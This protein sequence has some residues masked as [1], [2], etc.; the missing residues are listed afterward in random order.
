MSKK[1][2]AAIFDMDGTLI[3]SMWVWEKIDVEFLKKRNLEIP[4]NL[5]SDIEHMNF[6]Q[7]A[8]YF[9]NRFHLPD[10]IDE[11]T[12]EWN[13]M[14]YSHYVNDVTLKNGVKE[15]LKHLKANGTK[16]GL[17]TSN[18]LMLIEAVLKKLEIYDFFDSITT[19]DEVNKGKDFPD[20]YILAAKKLG[21]SPSECIVFE[22]IL[23]AII[24]A[25]KAGAKVVGVHDDYALAQMQDIKNEADKFIVNF[26]EII[27]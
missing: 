18:C 7:V 13:D 24:S 8:E 2:K 11:I 1:I 23:P 25:K 22:D 19:T 6:Y 5:R 15:Y 10:S 3:D 14:A 27:A 26:E 9:K 4:N 20:I 12:K 21:V 16:I 17:A